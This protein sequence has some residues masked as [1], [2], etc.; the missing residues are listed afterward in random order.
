MNEPTT[1]APARPLACIV[2]AGGKGT[3]MR[4][5]L[6]KVL[7]AVCGRPILSWVLAA[8][9]EA[10]AERLVVVTPPSDE[11][12]RALVGDDAEAVIQPEARGTGDAVR[13]GLEA[14]AGFAGDVLVVSGDTPLIRGDLLHDIVE[15]HRAG[16]DALYVQVPFFEDDVHDLPALARV[17][18][19]LTAETSN[20]APIS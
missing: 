2:M 12:V 14:L 7:H 13:C 19:Y 4:S 20:A 10:G 3:R 17:A 18:S 8:A 16:H 11:A 9:R 15:S 6:P 5:Q 1:A